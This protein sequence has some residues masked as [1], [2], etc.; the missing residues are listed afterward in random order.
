MRQI[1]LIARD[2]DIFKVFEVEGTEVTRLTYSKQVDDVMIS[3]EGGDILLRWDT[4]EWIDDECILL[5][6][7]DN[8]KEIGKIS[9]T[10]LLIKS[11][12]GTRVK[13]YTCAQ[14]N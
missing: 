11:K 6:E 5:K 3:V 9:I 1:N 12:D 14:L 10:H 4:D 2:S 8:L 7:H 13:V